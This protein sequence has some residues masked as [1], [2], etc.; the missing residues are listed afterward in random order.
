M[1]LEEKYLIEFSWTCRF[2]SR[3]CYN[4][5]QP[6]CYFLSL[7]EVWIST[8]RYWLGSVTWLSSRISL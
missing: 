7:G 5:G 6:F 8:A 4:C 1:L 3:A 2:N